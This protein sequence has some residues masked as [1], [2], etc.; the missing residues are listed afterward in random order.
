M[1]RQNDPTIAAL[2]RIANSLERIADVKETR[3]VLYILLK[4]NTMRSLREDFPENTEE[5]YALDRARD[6][7]KRL[8]RRGGGLPAGAEDPFGSPV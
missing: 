3:F 7:W 2:E 1:P 8:I 6:I 4:R 5:G